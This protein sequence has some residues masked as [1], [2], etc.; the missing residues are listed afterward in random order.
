M[1]RLKLPSG[2]VERLGADA[3]SERTSANP[4]ASELSRH[5]DPFKIDNS[6]FDLSANG[7]SKSARVGS[8]T[9]SAIS[10]V[11]VE[12]D[13]DGRILRV[14]NDAAPIHNPLNDPLNDLEESDDDDDEQDSGKVYEE[15]GGFEDETKPGKK[16]KA[17]ASLSFAQTPVVEAL[18]RM[19]NQPVGPKQPRYQSS[20]ERDWLQN[21]VD[22]YGSADPNDDMLARM[23]R[24]RRRN[25]FQRTANDLRRRLA[26]FRSKGGAVSRSS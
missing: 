20:A 9:T 17:G 13:A 18:E 15:W 19:A 23:A 5:T 3:V 16:N 2:G 24:D 26:V 25:A 14:I 1:N 7:T 10:E 12:R 6:S 11:R 4:K 22:Y 21:L 8:K